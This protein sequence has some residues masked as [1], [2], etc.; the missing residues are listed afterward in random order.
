MGLACTVMNW[1]LAWLAFFEIWLATDIWFG[2][3]V[4]HPGDDPSLRSN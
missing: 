4:G 1:A 3:G 2:R